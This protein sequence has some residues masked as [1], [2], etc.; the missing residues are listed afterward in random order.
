MV[1]KTVRK[2]WFKKNQKI[3]EISKNHCKPKRQKEK[4]LFKD[5]GVKIADPLSYFGAEALN[6]RDPLRIKRLNF[7]LM[8]KPPTG[9]LVVS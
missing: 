1:K 4:M 7:I 2:V 9:L 8:P 6:T 5:G 3:R